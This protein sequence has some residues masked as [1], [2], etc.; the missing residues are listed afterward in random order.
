M[1][2]TSTEGRVRVPAAPSVRPA[3]PRD[4]PRPLQHGRGALHRQDRGG[5]RRVPGGPGG[6]GHLQRVRDLQ[7]P[8]A[9]PPRLQGGVVALQLH[10]LSARHRACRA[11]QTVEKSELDDQG[12]VDAI[13]AKVPDGPYHVDGL[14]TDQNGDG[15]LTHRIPAAQAAEP[16]PFRRNGHA[17]R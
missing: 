15:V 17:R 11:L 1:T 2:G 16:E 12:V 13:A 4:W 3:R 7:G 14:L 9:A 8:G 10:R 5:V 6:A